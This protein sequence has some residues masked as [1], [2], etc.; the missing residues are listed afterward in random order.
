MMGL[1]T[2][3][4]APFMHVNGIR[5]FIWQNDLQLSLMEGV[6]VLVCVLVGTR[7]E[8]AGWRRTVDTRGGDEVAQCLPVVPYCKVGGFVWWRCM[9]VSC[10]EVIFTMEGWEGGGGW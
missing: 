1:Q 10:M 6:V 8:M 7:S 9:L 5:I 2:G 3:L 4:N